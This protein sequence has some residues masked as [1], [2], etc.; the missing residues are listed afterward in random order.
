MH[1]HKDEHEI[2]TRKLHLGKGKSCQ[3]R[4][5]ELTDKDHRHQKEGVEEIAQPGRAF[6]GGAEIVE[7]PWRRDVKFDRVRSAVE[8]R[9]K[10]K[11]Q[12][13]NPDHGQ[14]KRAKGFDMPGKSAHW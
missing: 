14:K 2:P 1:Q 12:R 9:P 5:K 13:G 3:C 10:G 7:C 4:D 11:N 6:P 8:S